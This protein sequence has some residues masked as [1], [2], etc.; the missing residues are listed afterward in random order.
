MFNALHLP[1]ARIGTLENGAEMGGGQG[2]RGANLGLK[3]SAGFG[4]DGKPVV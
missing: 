2:S 4:H 1:L 3:S